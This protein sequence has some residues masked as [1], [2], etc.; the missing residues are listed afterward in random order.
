MK[1]KL[2][3]LEVTINKKY[4]YIGVFVIVLIL[5]VWGWYLSN[6]NIIII[7]TDEESSIIEKSISVDN[8]TNNE[9][10][11]N[12]NDRIINI[13][14]AGIDELILLEGI[15]TKTAQSIIDY[16]NKN[17]YFKSIDELTN[18]KGI[19]EKKLEQ[20]RDRIVIE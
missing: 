1:I 13:N 2:F 11:Y 6:R 17:G 4:L 19:G 15:G 9:I 8:N 12:T 16:R 18:V 5:F 20:I 3:G 14:T 7:K 10:D